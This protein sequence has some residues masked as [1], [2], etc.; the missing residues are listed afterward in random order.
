[1]K[2]LR[3]M[4]YPRLENR[5]QLVTSCHMG[6]KVFI[7]CA[8]F[9]EIDTTALKDSEIYVEVVDGSRIHNEAY[10]CARKLA[11]DA[12]EYDED[13]GNPSSVLEDILR[14][15]V[16]NVMVSIARAFKVVSRKE[17]QLK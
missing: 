10:K 11:V 4:T 8:G 13:E 15:E 3:G 1:M 12:L 6:Q 2:T 16:F 17:K 7:S 9:I 14:Q 5:Q